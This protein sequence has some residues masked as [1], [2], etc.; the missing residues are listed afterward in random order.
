MKHYYTSHSKRKLYETC[1][2]YLALSRMD[3]IWQMFPTFL[4]DNK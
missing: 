3:L 1:V 4:T 2:V